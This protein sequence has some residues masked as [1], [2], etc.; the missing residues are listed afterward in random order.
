MQIAGRIALPLQKFAVTEVCGKP[1]SVEVI[2]ILL[3][4][5]LPANHD[6]ANVVGVDT[7][8]G[9]VLTQEIIVIV[10]ALLEL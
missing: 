5:S 10:P 1:E 2:V 6:Y 9:E 3:G 7:P 8:C 4:Q